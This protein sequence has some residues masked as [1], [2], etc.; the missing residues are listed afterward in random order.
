MLKDW[1]KDSETFFLYDGSRYLD[2]IA[3]QHTE[4][5]ELKEKKKQERVGWRNFC[6]LCAFVLPYFCYI[7]CHIVSQILLSVSILMHASTIGQLGSTS[8]AYAM[9]GPGG[10]RGKEEILR[11][12]T[13]HVWRHVQNPWHERKNHMCQHHCQ[14]CNR[15]CQIGTSLPQLQH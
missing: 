1:E 4:W 11:K 5:E 12:F 6:F 13:V 7:C 2:R 3:S 10:I 8:I 15:T 14:P 9:I